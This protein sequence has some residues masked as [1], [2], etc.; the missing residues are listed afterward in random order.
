MFAI[1]GNGSEIIRTFGSEGHTPILTDRTPMTVRYASATFR[2]KSQSAWNP[3][4]TAGS[5][6]RRH[7]Y[8]LNASQR[9]P[10]CLASDISN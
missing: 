7:A 4:L 6:I 5:A 8:P 3:R 10:G 2:R 9:L 1:A